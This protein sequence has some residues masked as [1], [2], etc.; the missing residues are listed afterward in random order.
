MKIQQ[1]T[2]FVDDVA[3]KPGELKDVIK[4]LAAFLMPHASAARERDAAKSA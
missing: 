3:Y 4:D 1:W 2:S